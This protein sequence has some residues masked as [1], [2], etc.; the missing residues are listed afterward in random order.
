LFWLQSVLLHC[1]ASGV[2]PKV[3]LQRFWF[4]ANNSIATHWIWLL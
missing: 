1:D 4:V 2:L 3:Q